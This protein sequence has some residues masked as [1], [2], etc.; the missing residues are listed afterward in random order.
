[1]ILCK[2][3][4]DFFSYLKLHRWLAVFI[5]LLV[6]FRFSLITKGHF[7]DGD[8]GRY[9]HAFRFIKHALDGNPRRAL[10]FIFRAQARPGFVLISL[11]PAA[12][13]IIASKIGIVS[14]GNPHYFNIPS[15]LNVLVSITS[16]IIFYHILL[17]CLKEQKQALLGTIVYSLLCNTNLYIRHLLPHDYSLLFFLIA[18]LLILRARVLSEIT[19]RVAII[20]GIIS[21]FGFLIYP[22]YYLFFI[23]V[24]AFIFFSAKDRGRILVWYSLSA[25]VLI[26]AFELLSN[27]AGTSYF[28]NCGLINVTVTHG[29]FQEGFIFIFRYLRDVEGLI[30]LFLLFMFFIYIFII[31]PRDSSNPIKPLFWAVILSYWFHAIL[32]VVFLRM[33]FY[34]RMMHMYI[35][36]V[37]IGAMFA[38]N[39]LSKRN[40][41]LT[42]MVL[43][44]AL[45]I[46]SFFSFALEYVPLEYPRDLYLEYLADIPS[47]EILRVT[48][49]NKLVR[50]DYDEYGAVVVNFEP[51][52]DIKDEFYVLPDPGGMILVKTV[53]HTLKFS[54]YTFE[55][56]P[57]YERKVLKD[58]NYQMRIYI[59]PSGG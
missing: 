51:Y 25:A 46:T 55:H 16:A 2:M 5:V 49:D 26:V 50:P 10:F 32:G 14:I 43:M 41:R 9:L 6:I 36:F 11:I 31:L 53:A 22:A 20:G 7:F 44:F 19:I 34:G 35:P 3:K 59:K 33:V 39:S 29:S 27:I 4:S 30:G 23:I 12:L 47:Q 52:P 58:R 28:Y 54:A 8:E 15:A 40:L 48:E 42:I 24:S 38:I 45:S 21:A 18:I 13:Q 1:M 17:L 57:P 56:Y 37:V